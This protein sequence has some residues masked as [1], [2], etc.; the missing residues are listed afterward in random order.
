MLKR[1]T[2]IVISCITALFVAIAV[3]QVLSYS[4]VIAQTKKSNQFQLQVLTDNPCTLETKLEKN[5]LFP[6][7][8]KLE[9]A[10]NNSSSTNSAAVNSSSVSQPNSAASSS[11]AG[12]PNANSTQTVSSS[13]TPSPKQNTSL[14]SAQTNNKIPNVVPLTQIYQ[15][16]LQGDKI[17]LVFVPAPEFVD[18]KALQKQIG[19]LLSL[20]GKP[21]LVDGQG[22]LTNNP[23]QVENVYFGMFGIDPFKQNLHKFNFWFFDQTVQT[24]EDLEI[25]R[26]AL[27][28]AGL[29]NL[30]VVHVFDKETHPKDG[31]NSYL[32]SF[33]S[34]Q[35]IPSKGDYDFGTVNVW[36]VTTNGFY[37]ASE[38][39]AHEL[40]H[41]L[42]GLRDEYDDPTGVRYGWPSC[43]KDTNEAKSW[44]SDLEGQI[45]PFYY[46]WKS[47]LEKY[48]VWT[49][50]Y[51][52]QY[53]VANFQVGY[54]SGGCFGPKNSSVTKPTKDSLMNSIV[55]ILGSVNRKR[56]E[57]VLATFTPK[58]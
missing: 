12:N 40:G 28:N 31:D 57:L 48:N 22:H 39:L 20:D 16:D 53:P 49:V 43:A 14:A 56:V 17:N 23:N 42:F 3:G 13:A 47:T 19:Q 25:V 51:D 41:A 2:Q 5:C 32:A 58:S 10:A 1:L 24:S 35:E 55:P 36:H 52:V 9:V 29:K 38:V 27:A 7:I 18:L 21:I 6:E 33:Y 37:K 4:I 8:P 34:Q 11:S 15:N 45:D 54:F 46:T 26:G 44:W 30:D 50:W